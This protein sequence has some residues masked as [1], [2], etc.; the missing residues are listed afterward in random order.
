MKY[1]ESDVAVVAHHYVDY[2]ISG[3]EYN[4][5]YM[6]RKFHVKDK[7]K[8][9]VLYN[10]V[11]EHP[12]HVE[13][14]EN[15]KHSKEISIVFPGACAPAKSPEIVLQVVRKLAK[16][17]ANFK[18]YWMGRTIIH[19]SRHFPFLHVRDVR[20]LV[21]K[22]P[23]II[24]PGRLPTRE[25][26]ENLIASSNIQICPSRREGCPMSFLE[27]IRVGTI[28]IVADFGN[29]NRE[30]VEKGNFGYV[31]HYNDIDTFAE[32]IIDIC[33]NPK[34]YTDFYDNARHIF[35]KELCYEVWK[36]RMDNLIYDSDL[37]H[38]RR[39]TKVS[40][41]RLSINIL[42]MKFLIFQSF[43]NRTFF[44]CYKLIFRMWK[45]KRKQTISNNN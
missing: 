1:I 15:K 29:F 34:S 17:D 24:F 36:S 4:S 27:A 33:R 10:F 2:I 37:N 38:K 6:A 22:D 13:I 21:P 40:Y 16:T 23:R 31:I 12:L 30:I 18:F 43:F 44:E 9:R 25:E 11:K 5:Q 35:E 26:A 20:D 42:K 3:S 45:L 7:T 32:K 41:F 14:L 39:R 28:A 19:M 8:I